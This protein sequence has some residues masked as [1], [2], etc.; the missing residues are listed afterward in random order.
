MS[1]THAHG[2]K[3]WWFSCL[4]N[5]ESPLL[6][7]LLYAPFLILTPLLKYQCSH[8]EPHNSHTSASSNPHEIHQQWDINCLPSQH[9]LHMENV[10]LYETKNSLLAWFSPI[11]ASCPS[12]YSLTRLLIPVLST[13]PT[14][15]SYQ[16]QDL[17]DPLVIMKLE[18]NNQFFQ[19]NYPNL[20]SCK[21]VKWPT[22]DP[23][24]CVWVEQ[25]VKGWNG[26]WWNL[27]SYGS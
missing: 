20:A 15:K 12:K 19:F 21:V 26:I 25:N 2:F 23:R 14:G 18:I 8:I 16:F 24:S 11:T 3:A 5:C 10:S 4:E 9:S 27:T 6:I 7:L 22:I 13:H 17:H 1:Y